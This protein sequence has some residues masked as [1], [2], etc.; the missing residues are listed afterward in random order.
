MKVLNEVYKETE[1]KMNKVIDFTRDRLAGIRA[2]R[3]NINMLDQV[4]VNYYGS[5]TAL[6]ELAR[7]SA[8]EPRVLTIDPFDK[9]AIRDIEKGIQAS[10]LGLTPSNDGKVIRINIPEL[11]EERRKEYLKLAKKETEEGKVG[12]RNARKDINNKLRKMQKDSE[13]TEDDLKT[14]EA[15]V[16]IITDKYIV[17]VDE[18]YAKKEKEIL[19]R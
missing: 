4:Y 7:L 8:P 12:V 10:G 13:I 15:K 1:E 9:G 16:Q 11:T 5:S 6:R 18:I 17:L 14:G 2:G 19:G 3:A